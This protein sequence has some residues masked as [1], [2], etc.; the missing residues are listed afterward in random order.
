MKYYGKNI[1]LAT[2][3][4]KE[5]VVAPAIQAVCNASIVVAEVDT[6]QLGTFSGEVPRQGTPREVV[7]KKA[8]M[9]MLKVNLP[10]GIATEGSF[11][12]HPSLPFLPYHEE[13]VVFIDDEIGITLFETLGTDTTNFQSSIVSNAKELDEFASRV[14]FPEHGVI[15]RPYG[16]PRN[17]SLSKGITSQTSL[18]EAFHSARLMSNEG[19]VLIETDM[20]AHLNPTR[21][22]NIAKLAERLAKR[23]VTPCPKCGSPG[24]G[25]TKVA[26]GLPCCDCG[27]PTDLPCG[28]VFTCTKC[29]FEEVRAIQNAT[30][31][32][33]S[34]YCSLCNP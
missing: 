2:K 34:M 18:E 1:S 17:V 20:R 16:T 23:L 4:G 5:L 24:W 21:M 19:K 29:R 6:D 3:H 32:M 7:Q 14:K 22:S 27:S 31:V 28:E 13:V 26:R 15:I 12:P 33:S 10:Y 9:G 25:A 30:E 11:G 8:R